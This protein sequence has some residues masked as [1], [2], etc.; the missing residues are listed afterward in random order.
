MATVEKILSELDAKQASRSDILVSIGGGIASDI[1]GFA[2]SMWKRGIRWVNIPTTLLSMVDASVGGKTGVNYNQGKNIIGAFHK[3]SL[4]LI[5]SHF[6]ATLSEKELKQGYAEAYKH[7]LLDEE[8]KKA[9]LGSGG[10]T[11][12]DAMK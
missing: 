10:S 9:F 11:V 5:D 4:V 7:Y 12:V 1:T 8:L 2:A 3:P 6:L